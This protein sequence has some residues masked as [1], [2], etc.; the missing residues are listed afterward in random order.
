VCGD[1]GQIEGAGLLVVGR[2]AFLLNLHG[3]GR[4]RSR[5]MTEGVDFGDGEVVEDMEFGGSA[6][7]ARIARQ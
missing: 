1:R 2:G 5:S 6:Q 4:R 7:E 3:G